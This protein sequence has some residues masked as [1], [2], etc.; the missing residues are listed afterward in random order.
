MRWR[1]K[2][3][4]RKVTLWKWNM[5]NA[6]GIGERW[7][8]GMRHSST[9]L[10]QGTWN[11]SFLGITVRF[12]LPFLFFFCGFKSSERMKNISAQVWHECMGIN[13]HNPAHNGGSSGILFAHI[14]CQCLSD[15][16]N[17]VSF[18][19][20]ADCSMSKWNSTGFFLTKQSS[21]NIFDQDHYQEGVSS[22]R[23][24]WWIRFPTVLRCQP[25]SI[26]SFLADPLFSDD[27]DDATCLGLFKGPMTAISEG[28]V[29][30]GEEH[31]LLL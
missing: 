16:H 25:N 17:L 15:V 10:K 6:K 29:L 24:A 21:S 22:T 30:D 7:K 4:N 20:V 3:S 23:S 8:V 13:W 2:S 5:L 28:L 18:Q 26:A 19:S 11:V 12:H 9:I 27:S 31:S 14:S 1:R